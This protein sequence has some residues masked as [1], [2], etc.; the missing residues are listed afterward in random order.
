MAF[1]SK[2]TWLLSAPRFAECHLFSL[3]QDGMIHPLAPVP[4]LRTELEGRVRFVRAECQ[5]LDIAGNLCVWTTRGVEIH[6][7][8]WKTG[9]RLWVRRLARLSFYCRAHLNHRAATQTR[10]TPR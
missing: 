7:W 6:G 4:I 10:R 1:M 2:L 9:Q 8:N 3:S 5:R